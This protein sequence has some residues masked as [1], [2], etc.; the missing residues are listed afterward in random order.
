MHN[1]RL[2]T[3]TVLLGLVFVIFSAVSSEAVIKKFEVVTQE[4]FGS[5]TT[6]EYVRLTGKVTG[7]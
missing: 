1:F 5:Y 3:A 4:G 2:K 7:E 6:W